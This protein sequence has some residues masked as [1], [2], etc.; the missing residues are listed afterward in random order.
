MSFRKEWLLDNRDRETGDFDY[1]RFLM[2]AERDLPSAFFCNNDVVALMLIHKLRENGYEVP[3][4][5]SVVGF[6]NYVK[7]P[8]DRIGIT[9]YV[10][11]IRKMTR[12][13]IR[14][15]IHKLENPDYRT[16]IYMICTTPR[17]VIR[18]NMIQE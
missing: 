3:R 7:E 12:R 18:G 10:I 8:Y 5:V 16:G 6:D 9:T 1:E 2:L 14:I 13:V 4:D 11:N 17:E 15:E